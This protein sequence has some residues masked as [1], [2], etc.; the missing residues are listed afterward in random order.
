MSRQRP[1]SQALYS[2]YGLTCSLKADSA[3]VHDPSLLCETIV[4]VPEM[5][6]AAAHGV[7]SSVKALASVL[8][9]RDMAVGS[10]SPQLVGVVVGRATPARE[11]GQRMRAWGQRGSCLDVC[12][13]PTHTATHSW[14][15]LPFPS[16]PVGRSTQKRP[17]WSVMWTPEDRFTGVAVAVDRPARRMKRAV[18]GI[19]AWE[20]RE[21]QKTSYS[22]SVLVVFMVNRAG[23]KRAPASGWAGRSLE[24]GCHLLL[25]KA[26]LSV[27][28]AVSDHL[29]R[30]AKERTMLTVEAGER[31]RG[32]S[33]G[34]A[35]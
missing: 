20:S 18:L 2:N 8:C 16:H 19:V 12:R 14:I 24:Q 7:V 21:S 6:G 34:S 10:Q 26:L 23:D 22:P 28:G 5:D 29:L 3:V 35:S 33:D 30:D 17:D 13:P 15:L 11:S 1:A 32:R 27:Q 9:A 25:I 4:T 31:A